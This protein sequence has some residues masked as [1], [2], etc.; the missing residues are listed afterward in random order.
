[1]TDLLK[2]FGRLFNITEEDLKKGCHSSIKITEN[3]K[4]VIDIEDGVDKLAKVKK[5]YVKPEIKAE[6]KPKTVNTPVFKNTEPEQAPHNEVVHAENGEP[7]WITN[8]VLMLNDNSFVAINKV[9]DL[10]LDDNQTEI[11]FTHKTDNGWVSGITD[12]QLLSILLY[13]FRN[14]S[15][16]FNTIK[17]LF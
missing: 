15:A 9:K 17:R 13:R 5:P 10:P 4:P 7:L 12:E 6:T 11:T 16:K 3:G 8:D 2:E 14:D 1:M